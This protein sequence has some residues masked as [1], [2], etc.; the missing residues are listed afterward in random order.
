MPKNTLCLAHLETAIEKILPSIYSLET[1]S[2]L[3]RILSNR[4]KLAELTTHKK[5]DDHMAHGFV[6]LEIRHEPEIESTLNQEAKDDQPVSIET[7]F[8][9][10][11]ERA[12]VREESPPTSAK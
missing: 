11:Q 6:T 8:V 9:Q 12:P 7:V 1:R 4:Q 10:S 2:P 5:Y 3:T